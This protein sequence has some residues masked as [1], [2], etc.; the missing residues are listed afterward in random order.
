[1]AAMVLAFRARALAFVAGGLAMVAW[2]APTPLA[3]LPVPVMALVGCAMAKRVA[4]RPLL[5]APAIAALVGFFLL[6]REVL[7]AMGVLPPIGLGGSI[8]LSYVM[9]RLIQLLVD[10]AEGEGPAEAPLPSLMAWLLFPPSLLAGPIGRAQDFLED[11]AAPAAWPSREDW[12]RHGAGV[13]GGLFGLVVLAAAPW[14][15]FEQAMMRLDGGAPVFAGA[16][17]GFALWLWLSFAGYSR[18]AVSLAGLMGVRLP[19]N[20]DRPWSAET[21]LAVWSRWHIS[22]SDWFRL[23]VFNPLLK[24]LLGVTGATKQAHWLGALAYGGTFLLMGL[25]HGIG[26]R[27]ALYGLLLG[28]AAG[29]NKVAQTLL[30]RRLGKAG[31]AA[32]KRRRDYALASSVGAVGTFV[33]ALAF[34]WLPGEAVTPGLFVTLPLAA[35][36]VCAVLALLLPAGARLADRAAP[37]LAAR[38]GW[39][40]ALHLAALIGALWLGL[41]PPPLLYQFF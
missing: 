28:A 35:L 3:M 39:V 12:M 25:W 22:L 6:V 36:I 2:L 11:L 20:F 27:F 29:A 40:V 13:A 32:L 10:G 37:V 15:V 17:L 31:Y 19:E 4:T 24:W 21:M 30:A 8:G 33:M 7:P 18:L 26:L 38:Q 23:Y 34:L 14:W 16:A 9:F 5:L 41:Q 1:M